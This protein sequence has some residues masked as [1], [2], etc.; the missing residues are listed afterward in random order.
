MAKRQ[1]RQRKKLFK[2]T[3]AR[4][5]L[6]FLGRAVKA[7]YK[8]D[9]RVREEFN[10]LPEGFSIR[11]AIKPSGPFIIFS[12]Q[13]NN[14]SVSKDSNIIPDLDIQFKNVESGLYALCAM[15]S[16]AECFA[17][18]RFTIR[19]DLSYATAFV[20]IMNIVESYLFPKVWNAVLFDNQAPIRERSKTRIYLATIFGK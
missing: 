3:L 6:L 18:H 1:L 10:E 7:C 19:G 15:K 2:R 20:R 11:L 4:I 5:I 17:E 14:I 9:S 12:R 16:V 8:L 13:G